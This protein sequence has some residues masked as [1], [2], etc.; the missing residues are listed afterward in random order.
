MTFQRTTKSEELQADLV[1][2]G[3]GGA[4]L[5]ATV[6]AAEKGVK[7]I[8]LLES[9]S[10]VGGNSVFAVNLFTPKIQS[11]KRSD[12]NAR[13][14]EL[15]KKAMSYAHWK[16]SPRLVRALIDK[17]EDILQW[18][19]E[20]GLKLERVFDPNLGQTE[21]SAHLSGPGT[22]GAKM[23]KALAR[24][25]EDLGVRILCQNRAKKLLISKEGKIIG[26]L[27]EAKGK[28]TRITTKSV[29]I[30][31][32]GFAGNKE[33]LKKYCPTYSEEGIF[34]KGLPYQGDG[35]LMATEAGAAIDGMILLEM[36]PHEF[37]G[38][39]SH[40]P[41]IISR[42]RVI[43]VNKKGER[44]TDETVTLSFSEAANSIY[45]QP[46]KT[47]YTLFDENIKQSIFKEELS[48][49]QKRAIGKRSLTTVLDNDLRLYTKK[50][51]VKISDSWDEIAK[52]IGADPKVLKT[53]IDEYNAA[54]DNGYDDIFVK[55]RKYLLPLRTP[56][57]YAIQ[58]RLSLVDTHGGIKINH[59]ME[60]L[61]NQD[62][63][64]PGLYAAGDD[65]GDVDSDTYNFVAL[66]G[67]SFGSA[68][69]TGRI[70]GENAA[71]FVLESK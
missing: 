9:R 49:L 56:P 45:R 26:V 47:A 34:L 60:V 48:T 2:V 59:H 19:E 62:N 36:D 65:T 64:I 20:K 28:E 55:D 63:S 21:M 43:W 68:I 12:I 31:T 11:Q 42:P 37:T 7:N 3:G 69:N 67:H 17:S 35:L 57:Y 1:V 50:G 58:H 66:P 6:V 29:I 22:T 32:G 23:V 15:F 46:G 51:R 14:D 71:K 18:L 33:L 44:F 5:A 41:I 38:G 13:S 70:A 10:T 27:A 25:C 4:G 54:C 16:N 30:A 61:D 8:I 39:P 52:W 40:L 53:T 24:N